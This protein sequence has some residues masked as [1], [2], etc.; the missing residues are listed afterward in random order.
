MG[1]GPSLK[2]AN[3]FG[4]R[5]GVNGSWFLVLFLFIYW[6]N[7]SF[8]QTMDASESTAFAVAVIAAL[9]FFG[10]IVLHELGHALAARRAGIEV[11]GIDLFFF[12]GV[13]KMSSDSRTPGEEFRIAA[14]GPLVTLGLVVVGTVAGVALAG[15]WEGFW[16]SAR[17][18]SDAA[19]SPL[20]VIVAFLVTMN[21]LLLAFNLIP[22]FPLDGGRIARAIAWRVT[23][24]RAKATKLAAVIGQ[25]FSYLLIGYGLWRALDG[26]VFNGLWLVVLGWMLGGAARGAVAQSAFSERLGGVTVADIMDS[27]PVTIPA[28]L[29]AAQAYEEYFLRYQGWDWFAVVDDDGHYL[30]IA[31]RPAVEHA[32]L[33]EEGGTTMGE[34]V[35]S[36]AD[37]GRVRADTPLE[38]L[39]GSEPL[40]SLGAL[41]AVDDS[42]RLR[43]VVTIDQVSRALQARLA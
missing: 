5:I 32:A 10:S 13:M 23:G 21:A 36:A 30:G 6:L 24:D 25:G 4:I 27:E 8:Q 9:L 43:G 34:V 19:A 7:D 17:L 33:H 3:L 18:A 15:G 16:D 22:A 29:T 42:G 40:R 38:Q 28:R 41:M 1:G 35:G 2:L 12:G 14:A 37:V 20:D 39:L 31:H 11:S 26:E